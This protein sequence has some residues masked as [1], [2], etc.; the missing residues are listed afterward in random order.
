[1]FLERWFFNIYC[2]S[3]WWAYGIWL[4]VLFAKDIGHLATLLYLC[5][6]AFEFV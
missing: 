3:D 4:G 6:L 2:L 5:L 1:M